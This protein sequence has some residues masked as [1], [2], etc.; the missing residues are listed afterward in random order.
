MGRE[1]GILGITPET[2]VC[3]V[4]QCSTVAGDCA[5][6]GRNVQDG[7]ESHMIGIRCVPQIELQ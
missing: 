7:V 5:G 3:L 1:Q 4:P 2:V 6:V